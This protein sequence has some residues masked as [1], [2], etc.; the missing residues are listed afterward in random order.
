PA[1]SG[2]RGAGPP[3]PPGAGAGAG[4]GSPDASPLAVPPISP[5]ANGRRTRPART[6]P[7]RPFAATV[8]ANRPARDARA[9]ATGRPSS[10]TATP[11]RGRTPPP[12]R[13]M[14]APPLATS[15]DHRSQAPAG[16]ATSALDRAPPTAKWLAI[17]RR[18]TRVRTA[19]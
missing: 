14:G 6:S 3:P 12:D 7:R 8:A 9:F 10:H 16:V 19:R 13:R 18:P 4:A 17:R 11:V 2:T 1:R 5:I 15:G